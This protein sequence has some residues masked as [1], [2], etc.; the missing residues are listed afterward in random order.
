MRSNRNSAGLSWSHLGLCLPYIK[1]GEA[2]DALGGGSNPY[3]SLIQLTT[4]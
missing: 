4:I 3:A 2:D 1:A